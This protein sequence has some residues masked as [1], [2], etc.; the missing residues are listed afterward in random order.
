MMRFFKW[1]RSFLGDTDFA[2]KTTKMIE[3]VKVKAKD[4]KS[5]FIPNKPETKNTEENKNNHVGRD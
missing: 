2:K 1:L 4:V 3:R 5:K